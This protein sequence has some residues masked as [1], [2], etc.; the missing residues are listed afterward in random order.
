ML[1]VVI[2]TTANADNSTM[3]YSYLSGGLAYDKN[4]WK[5]PLAD[6]C[7]NS[8]G[9]LGSS[10]NNQNFTPK[11]SSL[12]AYLHG[13]YALDDNIFLDAK[14]RYLGGRKNGYFVGIGYHLAVTDSA[15]FYVLGGIS[16]P[17][18][19]AKM[20]LNQKKEV[21]LKSY[22]T[23]ITNK[24]MSAKPEEL[25]QILISTFG[26]EKRA[27][28]IDGLSVLFPDDFDFKED[29][30]LK[31]FIAEYG[32]DKDNV[33]N[34]LKDVI[35]ALDLPIQ[36]VI[37][38]SEIS[39]KSKIAPAVELGY[40]INFSDQLGIRLAYRGSYDSVRMQGK[41]FNPFNQ[42]SSTIDIKNSGLS[43]EGTVEATYAFTSNLMAE[44]GY[45][46]SQMLKI[47]SIK[48]NSSH[49]YTL[50]LRYAF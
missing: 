18:L 24:M 27:E 28:L 4:G 21:L 10:L 41:L 50:G 30:L 9:V 6:Y 38:T 15:D 14:L 26:K 49:R 32:V 17:D 31:D 36:K 34:Q 1:G 37:D 35:N 25:K 2:S 29:Q 43:H 19:P 16:Q 3:S 39:L 45:T 48:P 40:R 20:Q 8:I 42:E 12:G 47:G 13:S 11:R 44:A 7:K 22:Y 46:I 5:G 23:D 33:V